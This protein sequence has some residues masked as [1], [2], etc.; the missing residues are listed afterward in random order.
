MKIFARRIVV[1][2][3]SVNS[4]VD[5]RIRRLVNVLSDMM[6]RP[7]LIYIFDLSVNQMKK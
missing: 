2:Q 6:F 1:S 3:D 5:I 7:E 4:T